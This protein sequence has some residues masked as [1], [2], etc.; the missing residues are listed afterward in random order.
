M[1]VIPVHDEFIVREG[2]RQFIKMA[3]ERVFSDWIGEKGQFGTLG[4]KW[5]HSDGEEELVKIDI[6]IEVQ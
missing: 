2:D 3:L 6:S 4:A 1:P 5:T